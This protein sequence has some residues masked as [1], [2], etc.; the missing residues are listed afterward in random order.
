KDTLDHL[1]KK[2]KDWGYTTTQIHGGM[3]AQERRSRQIEF[4]R[5]AQVCVATEAAG[6]GI[7]LQFCHLMI[8]YDLPWN[9]N[10]LEQ[11]MGRIHRI[12]QER[13]VFVF[14]F[15]LTNTVEGLILQ[16]LLEKLEDIKA[17]LGDRVF[18][19]I[20]ELLKLNGLNL[21]E[22]LREAAYEPKDITAYLDQIELLSSERLKEY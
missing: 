4:Q 11:R 3:S 9:P 2:L 8:N 18:D 7:N 12:G 20:G 13:D 21:E 5:D 16:R 22:M 10:R 17:T 19:V 14:N 1:L 6:E 15:V